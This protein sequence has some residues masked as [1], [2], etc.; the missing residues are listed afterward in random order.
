MSQPEIGLLPGMDG[1]GLLFK[2]TE[3]ALAA[4]GIKA[5]IFDY[6]TQEPMSLDDLTKRVWSQMADN[7]PPILLGESYGGQVTLRLLRDHPGVFKGVIFCVTFGTCPQP[8]WLPMTRWFNGLDVPGPPPQV[9]AAH[10]DLRPK[11]PRSTVAFPHAGHPIRRAK[12]HD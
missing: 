4:R 5:R 12:S 11:N 1:T 9:G 7:P 2:P 3:A 10:L 6:P 8:F